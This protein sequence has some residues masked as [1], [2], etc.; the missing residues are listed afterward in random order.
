MKRLNKYITDAGYCS[1]READRYIAEGRVTINGIDAEIGSMV[2]E[3]DLVEV[4]GERV[5]GR[6]GKRPVY[7]AFN[8]P[9][10]VSSTSDPADKDN[11]IDFIGYKERIFHVGRLDKDSE[12]LIILTNDGDIVNKILRAGN[13]NPKEYIVTVDRPITNEFVKQMSSGVRILGVVT[14]D[15]KVIKKNETTFIIHLTQGLNRQIRRMCQVLGYKV[16]RLKRLKVM[17][18]ALGNLEPG[19]WRYF[20]PEETKEMHRLLADSSGTEEASDEQ[21]VV[22][23]NNTKGSYSQYRKKGRTPYV[24]DGQG[25][26]D[27]AGRKDAYEHSTTGGSG[28][29]STKAAYKHDDKPKGAKPKHRSAATKATGGGTKRMATQTNG[30]AGKRDLATGAKFGSTSEKRG[31][32]TVA[33]KDGSG[34]SIPRK[35]DSSEFVSRKAGRSASAVSR[36]GGSLPEKRSSATSSQRGKSGNQASANKKSTSRSR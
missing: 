12:G 30:V 27:E 25:R 18:I 21:K 10:G 19:R 2:E 33:R 23:K 11:I 14:K 9:V 29:S 31:S 28:H 5:G 1:R 8:K 15:C 22:P 36:R 24:R 34:V 6:G 35:N 20:T 3:G 16:V 7:I 32:T 4:D 13:N 17:N 26:S